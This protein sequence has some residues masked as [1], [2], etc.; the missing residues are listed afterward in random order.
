MS[1]EFICEVSGRRYKTA[2]GARESAKRERLREY[3]RNYV[4]LNA[5]TAQEFIDLMVK[6]SK[7]FYGWDM[8]LDLGTLGFDYWQNQKHKKE[9]KV[10]SIE[11]KMWLSINKKRGK[12][13]RICYLIAEHFEGVNL[14]FHWYDVNDFSKKPRSVKFELTLKNFPKLLENYEKFLAQRSVWFDYIGAKS[15]AREDAK[16]FLES[17]PDF[18][19]RCEE[20]S[21]ILSIL[22]KHRQKTRELADYYKDGYMR[23]WECSNGSAPEVDKELSD[24]FS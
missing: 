24:M 6:K 2:R 15:K 7:E 19:S 20:E 18:Q 13:K 9:D 23:I 12:R 4:R 1:T 8:E 21:R 11:A 3:Q 22:D 14:G 10:F 17:R 16:Y 5:G